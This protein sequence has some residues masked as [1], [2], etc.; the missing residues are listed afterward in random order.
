MHTIL[1]KMLFSLLALASMGTCWELFFLMSVHNEL[2]LGSH[3]PTCKV[4]FYKVH[5]NSFLW[6]TAVNLNGDLYSLPHAKHFG[7]AFGMLI[8][9]RSSF[10]PLAVASW[11]YVKE[12]YSIPCF[13]LQLWKWHRANRNQ[14]E[15]MELADGHQ[16]QGFY[17]TC[18]CDLCIINTQKQA[19]NLQGVVEGM[20][21]LSLP[22]CPLSVPWT[23]A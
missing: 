12:S 17:W 1:A 19:G 18:N 22:S 3:C 2:L 20:S 21:F 5:P 23:N 16:A 15:L 14:M 6:F 13:P 8:F 4:I 11:Q 9:L 10:S 7:K